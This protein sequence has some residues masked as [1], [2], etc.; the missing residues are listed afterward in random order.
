MR[1]HAEEKGAVQYAQLNA[2]FPA[3]E[4]LILGAETLRSFEISDASSQTGGV[5]VGFAAMRELKTELEGD[6]A[7]YDWD[8]AAVDAYV[9]DGETSIRYGRYTVATVKVSDGTTILQMYDAMYR[10]EQE[11][12]SELTLPASVE[13]VL[14]ELAAAHGYQVPGL[15]ELGFD[16]VEISEMPENITERQMIAYMM[17]L[18]GGYVARFNASGQLTFALYDKTAWQGEPCEISGLLSEDYEAAVT[19]TGICCTVDGVEYMTGNKGYVIEITGN[20]LINQGNAAETVQRIAANYVGLTMCPCSFSIHD[21]YA[22]ECTDAV[23]VVD[24]SGTAHDTYIMSLNTS[25]QNETSCVCTALP[26]AKQAASGGSAGQR[27]LQAAEQ[28]AEQRLSRYDATVRSLTDTISHGFGLFTTQEQQPDGSVITYLHD[29]EDMSQSL[30]RFYA[31][32]N[33]LIGQTRSSVAE[34]WTTAAALSAMGQALLQVLTVQGLNAG[35]INSGTF[36]ACDPDGNIVFAVNV[37]TGEVQI[38]AASITMTSGK[39]VQESFD[40]LQVGGRNLI[41]GSK[42]MFADGT[43][44]GFGYR[45]ISNPLQEAITITGNYDVA[46]LDSGYGCFSF[47]AKRDSTQTTKIAFGLAGPGG[48]I[49]IIANSDGNQSGQIE[50]TTEWKRHWFVFG[51]NPAQNPS[52]SYLYIYLYHIGSGNLP[53]GETAS[54]SYFCAPKLE[55]GN[56]PTDWTPAPEDADLK[57]GGRNLWQNSTFDANLD[58]YTNNHQY[59]GKIEAVSSGYSGHSALRLSRSNYTSANRCYLIGNTPPTVQEYKAGDTFTLSAWVYIETALTQENNQRESAIMVRGTAGDKPQITIPNE[60]PVGQW[61]LMQATSTFDADGSFANPFV[62][63]GGNGTMR[64]SCIKLEKGGIA[65]DWTPAPEDTDEKIASIKLKGDRI[66]LDGDTVVG[67]DFK[68]TAKH[69]EVEDLSALEATV[70]GWDIDQTALTKTVKMYVMPDWEDIER[71]KELMLAGHCTEQELA[72]YDFNRGGGL[73]LGDALLVKRMLLGLL[74]I[75]DIVAQYGYVKP[76]FDVTI[77]ISPGDVQ[78]TIKMTAEA[79]GRTIERYYGMMGMET[80]KGRFTGLQ[81]SLLEAEESNI[82]DLTCNALTIT[83]TQKTFAL[84]NGTKSFAFAEADYPAGTVA[85][86]TIT[87]VAG[88]AYA[89]ILFSSTLSM[90]VNSS[91]W[92]AAGTIKLTQ[93]NS[94][95]ITFSYTGAA[96]ATFTSKIIIK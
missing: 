60:T 22:L 75:D 31:T 21:D 82:A 16:G 79:Y 85:E 32:T 53:P 35:W 96:E 12:T 39:T 71:I 77:T 7:G 45:Y 88:A 29:N 63:L 10:H 86:L 69:I 58:G 89:L 55:N 91:T 1:E 19:V 68:L 49:T 48:S 76:L 92:T 8:N 61:V 42:G 72:W 17:Q 56:K 90:A 37:D 81:T 5:S 50:L 25:L 34:P 38:N 66:E 95:E 40:S 33:G 23:R 26:K 47:T 13:A 62:L 44:Q 73:D 83:G 15:S 51:V 14:T 52:A 28:K 87:G 30:V 2:A 54:S 36:A 67:D 24:R 65:T 46:Q 64:V 78:H 93:T 11:Y 43:Y 3:G 59:T 84:T 20:P 74:S 4:S 9:I 27:I 70:G 80:A 18:A 41:V 6:Y 57:V 94:R